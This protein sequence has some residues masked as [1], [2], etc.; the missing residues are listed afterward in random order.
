MNEQ[1]KLNISDVQT[2]LTN[3]DL[4]KNEHDV[5]PLESQHYPKSFLKLILVG[6]SLVGLPLT[7]ALMA[8]A[9][10][11]DDLANQS[12]DTIYKSTQ[13]TYGNR[14]LVDEIS[15]MERSVRQAS[16]LKDMS[17]LEGY[18]RAHA[19]F[20]KTTKKLL[21][22][23]LRTEQQL[24]LEKLRLSEATIFKRLLSMLEYPE[25]L[26]S[27]VGLF[28]E[29]FELSD[30]FS[31]MNQRFI[32]IE[33]SEMLDIAADARTNVEWQLLALIPCTILLALYFS[34]YLAR[35]IRQIDEA[36]NKMGQGE[37]SRPV[38]VTGPQSLIYLG[39][40]LDWMRRRLLKLQEQE[41][42]FLRHISH[43]L[44]TPLTAIREGTDI[45]AEGITGKL[46][47][48]QQLIAN[49]LHTSSTQLQKRIED[50]LNYSAIQAEKTTLV[51]QK[52]NLEHILNEVLKDQNLSIMAKHLHINQNCQN[53]EFECDRQK[54]KIIIDNLISNAVKFSPQQGKIDIRGEK[55][56]TEIQLNVIDAGVGIQKV[57]QEK[58]FEPF[59]QGRSKPADVH[60][61]KGTGLGLSIAR[62]YA[63][64]HGGSISLIK[65]NAGTHFRL[66]LPIHDQEESLNEDQI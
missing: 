44:K 34:F 18:F 9:L 20:E 66:T 52:V 26:Q 13:T 51:K 39:E 11:I 35:P 49:I 54:I 65:M 64:A 6:F 5:L 8:S 42:Q 32:G 4:G 27:L 41:N 3:P 36:I 58:I 57:D 16:I 48:K 30:K 40:R 1:P 10:S 55:S 29:L 28:S 7:L 23:P 43:E 15:I 63:L 33:V 50:L 25:Q 12:R 21:E 37:L 60:P 56:E 31:S 38:H 47:E 22:L 46:T 19:N 45:L 62:E 2:R 53:I 59:Y 24:I 61:V 17:L 14:V